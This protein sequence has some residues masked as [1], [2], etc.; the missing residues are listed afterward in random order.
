M[1]KEFI[2][3]GGKPA[4]GTLFAGTLDINA[5]APRL[6]AFKKRF[7]ARFNEPADMAA[8]RGYDAAIALKTGLKKTSL[9]TGPSIKQ[10]ILETG[11]IYAL[12]G[13]FPMD[14]YGDAKRPF[15]IFKV[16]RGEFKP[17]D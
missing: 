5:D 6:L 3:N 17:Q 11:I 12:N 7:N 14:K 15:L 10:A 16:E 13:D 4:E 8:A 1:R 2:E 9:L